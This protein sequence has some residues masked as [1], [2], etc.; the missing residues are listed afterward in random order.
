MTLDSKSLILVVEDNAYL[1]TLLQSI[2]EEE[3]FE[4]L[5]ASS[6]VEGLECFRQHA[7]SIDAVIADLELPQMNGFD[8]FLAIKSINPAIKC[9]I[10]SGFL[11]PTVKRR[12]REEGIIHFVD[13]PYSVN[14]VIN[15]LRELLAHR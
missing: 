9:V 3:G 8:L 7:A 12:F 14:E 1:R 2:L 13:K 4:V 5:Q 11:E 15:A 6:G 10:A